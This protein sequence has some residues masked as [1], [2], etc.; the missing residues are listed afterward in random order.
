MSQFRQPRIQSEVLRQSA[1][2]PDA[3]CTLRIPGFHREDAGCVLAHVRIDCAGMG[4]KPDDFCAVHACCA[5]HDVFDGRTKGLEYK[6]V[7]WLY[8]ALRGLK[9][10]HR[11]WVDHGMLQVAA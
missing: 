6:S 4:I 10:T 9:E 3:R 11:F 5:C 2:H 8:Y 1:G 7:D